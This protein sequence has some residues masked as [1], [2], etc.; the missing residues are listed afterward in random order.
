MN[1]AEAGFL[2]V[3]LTRKT[4]SIRAVGRGGGGGYEP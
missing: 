2:G 3:H 4:A 1:K